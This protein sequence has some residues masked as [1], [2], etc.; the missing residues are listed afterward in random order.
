MSG[1]VY[2]VGD[3]DGFVSR[4]SRWRSLERAARRLCELWRVASSE[5]GSVSPTMIRAA[6]QELRDA[7][8]E[9]RP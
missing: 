8:R 3:A 6:E 4:V 1:H 7:V 9:L 2:S 5:H